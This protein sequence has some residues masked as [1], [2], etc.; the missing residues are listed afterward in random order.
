MDEDYNQANLLFT[1]GQRQ[2]ALDSY[3]AFLD[4]WEPQRDAF[5]DT[6]NSYNKKLAIAYNN[7]GQLHY[8]NV[9]FYLAMEDYSQALKYN[10]HF[11]VAYYNRGQIHYRLG[12]YQLAIQ[13]LQRALAIEPNF[14]DARSNLMQA[15]Q[16]LELQLQGKSSSDTIN[17]LS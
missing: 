1:N 15:R 6:V 2:A 8:L 10:Q 5:G 17:A 14:E 7:R 9:D 13:D 16:D 4:K 3:T 12:S 11:A